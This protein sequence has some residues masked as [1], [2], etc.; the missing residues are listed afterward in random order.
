MKRLT[1]L[2]MALCLLMTVT[3]MAVFA[4]TETVI[5]ADGYADGGQGNGFFD[6]SQGEEIEVT[7]IEG[8]TAVIL[9]E[10]EWVKYD[11]SSLVSGTYSVSINV[12]S[13]ANGVASVSVDDIKMIGYCEFLASGS[14][15]VLNEAELG[16]IYIS[17]GAT[18]LK[19]INDKVMPKTRN[20]L[21]SLYHL[22]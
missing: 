3:P 10:K 4:E 19:L 9:R 16:K 22:R 13:T 5:S 2:F 1:A 18:E 14:M 15:D 6:S 21:S 12:G 7:E 17:E 11:I 20:S 8:K